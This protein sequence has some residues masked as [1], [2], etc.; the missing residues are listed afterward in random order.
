MEKHSNQINTPNAKYMIGVG[1]KILTPTPVP[2]LPRVSPPPP[3]TH[4]YRGYERVYN[5]KEQYI[6]SFKGQVYDWGWF[7]NTDLHT[8]TKI[9]TFCLSKLCAIIFFATSCPNYAHWMT[10]YHLELL[11]SNEA[12]PLA[13][14]SLETGCYVH[15]T[16]E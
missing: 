14:A 11:C 15:P 3:L 13:C 2:K 8:R 5:F 1:F 10:R 16:Y 7:Q 9:F 12:H 6:N 4:N